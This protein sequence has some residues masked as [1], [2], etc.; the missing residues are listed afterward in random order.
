MKITT[1]LFVSEFEELWFDALQ[2]LMELRKA[3][4]NHVVFLHVIPRDRVAMKR[5][6]GYLKQEERKLREIADIRF[7]DWAETLFEEGMEVG[8]HIAIGNVVPKIISV[9]E[10]E[11]VD[12]I[13]TARM[14]KGKLEEIFLGSETSD[15]IRRTE[16]PVLLYNYHSQAERAGE[17]PFERLLLALDW[18]VSSE[19]VLDF[20]LA[21]K[22]AVKRVEIMHVL[23]EKQIGKMSKMEA[24]KIERENKKRLDEVCDTF[25]QQRFDA[26]PHLY[27]GDTEEQI[28]RGAGEHRATM[29]VLGTRQTSAWKEKW[30]GSIS[31]S[32]AEKSELPLLIVP[33][34]GN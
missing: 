4:L 32:L 23:S 9:A 26:R 8:A 5:G 24:H 14:K 13:V 18:S 7:I 19:K 11:K 33:A 17:N 15:L 28:Q 12:L 30:S 10:I 25:V 16:K 21:M 22:E 29:I 31:H 6:T 3:G 20:V 2:S 34:G 27:I 1:M